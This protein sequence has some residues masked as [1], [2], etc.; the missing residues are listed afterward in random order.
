MTNKKVNIG[1]IGLGFGK[2]FIPI[3]QQHPNGGKI[4][5]CTRREQHL[6]EIGDQFKIDPALRYSDYQEMIQNDMLDAIHVVTPVMD[7]YPMV[8]A[9]LQSGKHTACTIP[10]ATTIQQCNDIVRATQKRQG[11]YDDGN[12]SLYP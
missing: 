3:Y 10:M 5:I 12:I 2:E 4:A 8:M 7:H 1:I 11:I 9:A 6:N